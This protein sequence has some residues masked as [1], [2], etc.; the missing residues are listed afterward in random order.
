MLKKLVRYGL[1]IELLLIFSFL[2][3][4]FRTLAVLVFIIQNFLKVA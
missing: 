2:K 4:N 3:A 1:W